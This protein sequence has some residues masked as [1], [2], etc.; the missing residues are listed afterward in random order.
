[1]TRAVDQM[2][3]NMHTELSQKM[4][5]TDSVIKEQIGKIVRGRVS[6][7]RIRYSTVVSRFGLVV[8]R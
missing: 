7:S 3:S 4:T 1:M 2:K 8:R 5:A 6:L